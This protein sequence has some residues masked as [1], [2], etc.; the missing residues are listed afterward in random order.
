M[1]SKA[2]VGIAM[3]AL[4][5]S[6]SSPARA[7]E[8]A[9]ADRIGVAPEVLQTMRGGFT[10]SVGGALLELSFGVERVVTVNGDI[11]GSTSFRI[12]SLQQ[13]DALRSVSLLQSGAGNS[14]AQNVAPGS[15]LQVVQNT[16]DNQVLRQI[17]TIN[18]SVR[19]LALHR[20]AQ[21]GG[22]LN[23]QLIMSVR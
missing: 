17:T 3:M 10:T 1:S 9:F 16:L 4:L 18:A 19:N 13:L 14:V 23:R 11:V 8:L 21:L 7:E 15:P 6:A 22:V 12:P 5:A 2:L 20:A